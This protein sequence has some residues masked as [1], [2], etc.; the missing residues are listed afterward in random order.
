[1]GA[2]LLGAT[3]FVLLAARRTSVLTFQG[4][5]EFGLGVVF[6]GVVGCH[7]DRLTGQRTPGGIP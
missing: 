7:P 1:M 6:G 4:L 3:V 2:R 5:A